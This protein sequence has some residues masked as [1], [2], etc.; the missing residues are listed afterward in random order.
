MSAGQARD[1]SVL[2]KHLERLLEGRRV[3]GFFS[4]TGPGPQNL[5]PRLEKGLKLPYGVAAPGIQNP[6][7]GVELRLQP[8]TARVLAGLPS[9]SG[10]ARA[11]DPESHDRLEGKSQAGRTAV[12]VGTGDHVCGLI[13]IADAVRE[14]STSVVRALRDAGIRHVV[15]LTGDNRGTAEAIARETGVDEVR[16]E[17]LPAEKVAA[18]DQLVEGYGQ[19]AMIGDGVNDAPAMARATLSIAMGAAGSRQSRV[20][21]SDLRRPRL[22]LGGDRRGHGS[23][24]A[25][26]LQRSATA[27]R[28]SDIGSTFRL[29]V[30]G[31]P[32]VGG[33]LVIVGAPLSLAGDSSPSLGTPL[34]RWETPPPR[35]ET[36]LPR[37]ETPLP[38]WGTPL[39]RWETPLPRWETPLPRWETPLPRWGTPLPRWETPLPRWGTP[40]HAEGHL[41]TLGDASPR[42]GTPPHAGGPFPTLGDRFSRW[43]TVPHAGET[44]PHG[45]AVDS[46]GPVLSALL[47]R[48]PRA[49]P[50]DCHTSIY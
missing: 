20:R 36:P 7:V 39:P 1:R 2:R 37:W 34:P 11:G 43:G 41:P 9:L 33:S 27:A 38:R 49:L 42:W 30:R 10:R 12:V 8:G 29:G 21:R 50:S 17:L 14:E 45:L 31:F 48:P 5:R 25:G 35:W 3:A 28:R 13:A 46:C 26:H 40:P 23:F 44:F 22:A 24:P 32:L 47:H 19:V 16:A 6:A 18:V 15:I 4:S